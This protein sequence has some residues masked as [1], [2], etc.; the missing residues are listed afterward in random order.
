MDPCFEG[1]EEIEVL[2]E[3]GKA[4]GWA[5]STLAARPFAS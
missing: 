1:I 4:K 3:K 5:A 2:F